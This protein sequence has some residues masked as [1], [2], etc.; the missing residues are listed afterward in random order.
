MA[1]QSTIFCSNA[2]SKRHF[3]WLLVPLLALAACTR[4]TRVDSAWSEGAPRD[5]GFSRILVIG[6]GPAYNTRCR[7]ERMMRDS[8]NAIGARAET[9][10]AYMSSK[11]PLSRET[12][13]RIVAE[14]G[15][16]AVFSTRLV[17]GSV[18]VEVGGTDEARGE[19]YYKPVGYGYGY[20]YSYD[21]YYGAYGLPVTYVEFHSEAPELTVRRSVVISSNLYDASTA[22]LVYTLDT[23][24][25]DKK[26]QGDVIDALSAAIAER[27][28]RDGLVR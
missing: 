28:Q 15:L 25:Y 9:S 19:A 4:P 12:V 14:Q 16:D 1:S 17:D 8:L 20:G 6:V 2:R 5:R 23:V 22:A 7:F 26:S 21:P 11:E 3:L 13:V 10:C 27:L 18:G 24:T